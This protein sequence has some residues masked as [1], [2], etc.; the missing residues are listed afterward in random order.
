MFADN[1]ASDKTPVQRVL[2]ALEHHDCH[3]KRNGKGWSGQCPAH[4]DRNPSLSVSEGDDGRALLH[5]HAGCAIDVICE[6]LNLTQADLFLSEPAST[7]FNEPRGKTQYR[8]HDSKTPINFFPSAKAAIASLEQKYGKRS[9]TWTY[10]DSNENPVGVIVRW[11]SP[12]GKIIRPVA[13]NG[14]GWVVGGMPEPR[15]LYRRPELAD[16]DQVFI[17]EGE[18]AVD[19]ACDIGLTATTSAH[20]AKSPDKTDWSPLAGKEC[21]ILPDNDEAGQ[22]YALAVA[23]ILAKLQPAAVVKVVDLLDLPSHGDIVDWIDARPDVEADELRQQVESLADEAE[24]IQPERRATD[25][26]QFQPFPTDILPEPI[27][28]FVAA[29]ARA[30]GCDAAMIVLPLLAALA[31]AIGATRRIQ[32]KDGWC[33]P[34][35]LWTAI[36]AESGSHKSP[37]QELALRA[38]RKIQTFKLEEHPELQESYERNLLL[39]DVDLKSWKTKGVKK[40]EHPPEKPEEPS[41]DRYLVK[42][43]TLEALAERLSKNPR[44]LLVDCD[45]L[46]SWFG[47]FDQYRAGKGGDASKWLSMH[48]AEPLLID[49]KTGLN[50]N[51]FIKFAAVSITGGIQPATLCRTLGQEHFENGLA[52]RMLLA[53]PPKRRKKWNTDCVDAGVLLRVE[54]VFARLLALKFETDDNDSP[55]PRDLQLTSEGQQV[56]VDFFDQHAGLQFEATGKFAAVLAKIEAVAARLALI[57]HLARCATDD[58]TLEDLDFVDAASMRPGVTMARW[59]VDE[60]RRVYAVF[61]ETDQERNQ[62]RLVEWIERQSKPVTARE[63]QQGCRWL[64]DS[65]AAEEALNELAKAGHGQ[66]E[67]TPPGRRGQPTRRFALSAMSTVYGNAQNPGQDINT[68]DV[69]SVDAPKT[70]PDEE[71]GEL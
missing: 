8:S 49:R 17:C 43:I 68:V 7:V 37:A 42:D 16:Q 55:V 15:P 4:Q 64:R 71:W 6:K 21:V 2:T 56:W 5:C 27:R 23:A 1:D 22:E 20:G 33:E 26:K 39:Y 28:E 18:K 19:A 60:A 51:L 47:S 48:R 70:Q 67:P 65:G 44:G 13:S 11:E 30:I 61:S 54:K 10:F 14:T 25:I 24:A 34:A 40:G 35:V 63:V 31:S 50:K 52:A 41:V 62:R 53:A 29:G 12:D 66:W 9:A 46:A 59:F 32:L 38:L 45:E 36:V 69:D 57:V 58:P 3:P